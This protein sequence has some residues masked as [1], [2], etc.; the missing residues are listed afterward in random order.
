MRGRGGACGGTSPRGPGAPAFVAFAHFCG[1]ARPGYLTARPRRSSSDLAVWESISIHAQLAAGLSSP[2]AA[3]SPPSDPAELLDHSR[4][5]GRGDGGVPGC[6]QRP[7]ASDSTWGSTRGQEATGRV[8]E[9]PA[10]PSP[11]KGHKP[12]CMQLRCPR[13]TDPLTLPVPARQTLSVPRCKQKHAGVTWRP[14]PS[15]LSPGQ[16]VRPTTERRAPSS[17]SLCSAGKKEEAGFQ[18]EEGRVRNKVAVR[19]RNYVFPSAGIVLYKQDNVGGCVLVVFPRHG[20]VTCPSRHLPGF[21]SLRHLHSQGTKTVPA[22]LPRVA[23]APIQPD[24]PVCLQRAGR[25]AAA[26]SRLRILCPLR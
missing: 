17:A 11:P 1:V 26:G 21:L 6:T 12:P 8:L 14:A 24:V 18:V 19:G 4:L 23:N 3:S 16:P 5:S 22:G 7:L 9:A 10:R 25:A 2:A 13:P 20:R 15:L